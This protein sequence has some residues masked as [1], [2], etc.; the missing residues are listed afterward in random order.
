MWDHD[1][2]NQQT[3]REKGES[4]IPQLASLQGGMMKQVIG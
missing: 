1:W 3:D 4:S 2:T